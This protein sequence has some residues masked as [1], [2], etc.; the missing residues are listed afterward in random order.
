MVGIYKITNNINGKSYIGLSTNIKKRWKKHKQ[1]N[2]IEYFK[3]KP[4]Y[5][6]FNKYGIDNFT[7]EVLEECSIEELSK[8]EIYYIDK[9]DSFGKNGYNATLGGDGAHGYKWSEELKQK[10][11]KTWKQKFIDN[12]ELKKQR[13]ISG[14]VSAKRFEKSVKIKELN[15]EFKTLVSCAQ[16]LIDN[17]YTKSNLKVVRDSVSRAFIGIRKTYLKFTFIK[18]GALLQ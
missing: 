8:K 5:R 13:S 14:K 16:W 17:N 11:S 6:A 7:F 2:Y 9:Y 3:D 4:L 15:K 18:G 10:S 12:P 1:K